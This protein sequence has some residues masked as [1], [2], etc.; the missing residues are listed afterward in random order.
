[1][2]QM[3]KTINMLFILIRMKTCH[4]LLLF[5][6]VALAKAADDDQTDQQEYCADS[7]VCEGL[8]GELTCHVL[9]AGVR[10][11]SNCPHEN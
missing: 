2:T 5:A 6:L 9:D 3:T 7:E 4:C 11:S 10:M 1:M 8:I